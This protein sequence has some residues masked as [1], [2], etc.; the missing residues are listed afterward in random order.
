MRCSNIA[1]VLEMA[2]ALLDRSWQSPNALSRTQRCRLGERKIRPCNT[3][4]VF[5]SLF[6][7]SRLL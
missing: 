6:V 3:A 2:A 4:A 1:A 7:R 5:S